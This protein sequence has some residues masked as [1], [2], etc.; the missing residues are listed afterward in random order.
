MKE[1]ATQSPVPPAPAEP[2]LWNWL[3]DPTNAQWLLPVTGA[4]ILGLD[5]LLFAENTMSL[6]LATPLLVVAGFIGGTL[7]THYLPDALRRRSRHHRLGQSDLGRPRRRPPLPARR[8]LRRRLDPLQLRPHQHPRPIPAEE[9]VFLRK[10]SLLGS[11]PLSPRFPIGSPATESILRYKPAQKHIL[12]LLPWKGWSRFREF[13][14]GP[15]RWAAPFCAA[16]AGG[17]RACFGPVLECAGTCAHPRHRHLSLSRQYLGRRLAASQS[18]RHR[19]RIRSRDSRRLLRRRRELREQF[20]PGDRR[21]NPHRALR[22][23]LSTHQLSR[24]ERRGRTK[25]TISFR[26]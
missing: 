11:R 1:L 3:T 22:S 15:L 18:I 9:I 17:N 20:Q 19:L 10:N 7:G 8:H 26:S 24:P 16:R 14:R 21:G 12:R 4:W 13:S 6:Y 23:R 25:R 5:W 2:T